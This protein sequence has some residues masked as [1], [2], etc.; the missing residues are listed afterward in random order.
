M[1][2]RDVEKRLVRLEAQASDGGGGFEL[3]VPDVDDRWMIGPNGERMLAA[4]VDDLFPCVI[5]IGAGA[6]WA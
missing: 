4:E 2:S 3:W 1:R 5:D 6:R